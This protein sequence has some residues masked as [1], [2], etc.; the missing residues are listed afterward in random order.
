ALNVDSTENRERETASLKRI[1]D[2]FKK[3]VIVRNRIIPKHDNHGIL[4]MGV[5]DFL[6][7]EAIIDL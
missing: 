6:L 2:S 5:E 7:N 4:Y 3:I 1:D